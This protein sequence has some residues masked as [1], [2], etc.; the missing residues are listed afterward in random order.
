MYVRDGLPYLLEVTLSI[1]NTDP[2]NSI[3]ITHADYYDDEG[4]LLRRYIVDPI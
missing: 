3:T 4:K 1:R 2:Q